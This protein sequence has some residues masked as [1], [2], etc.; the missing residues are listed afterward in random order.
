MIRLMLKHTQFL[1]KILAMKSIPFSVR[2]PVWRGIYVARTNVLSSL[3]GKQACFIDWYYL[4]SGSQIGGR[5][6]R[7]A[8]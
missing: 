8:K 3:I 7:F 2:Y 5:R 4:Y 1:D 6:S